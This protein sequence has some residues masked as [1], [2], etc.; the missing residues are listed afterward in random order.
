[1]ITYAVEPHDITTLTWPMWEACGIE[2]PKMI[3]ADCPRDGYPAKHCPGYS[4][5]FPSAAAEVLYGWTMDSSHDEEC[6]NAI[7]GPAWHAL[8]RTRPAD[9]HDGPMGAGAIFTVDS[10]GF[11]AA[12][13]YETIS[14]LDADW[15]ALRKKEA[16]FDRANCEN[17]TE[18]N[19]P[20]DDHSED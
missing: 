10:Q 14:E 12:T 9:P 19:V 8:F 15:S 2:C 11:T 7:E 6:G 1:M 4:V 3:G 16:E 5:K 20:C 13:L 18:L 17:C